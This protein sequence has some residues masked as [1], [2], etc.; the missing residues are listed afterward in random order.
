MAGVT[1][2][3]DK[4]QWMWIETLVL[5]FLA[6][7]ALAAQ[8]TSLTVVIH[9]IIG[10]ST[11]PTGLTLLTSGVNVWFGT[12]IAFAVLYWQF[13]RDGP[14]GR[15]AE[16]GRQADW[17]FPADTNPEA[18]KPG[19]Q[20]TFVDYLFLSFS[21]ATAFSTTDTVPLT[22]RAKLLMM[23][24]AAMSLATT[25]VVASRAINILGS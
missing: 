14:A 22:S 16:I 6:V 7:V 19:W 11:Q 4:R 21:T 10:G 3:D 20:P 17:L 24:E 23:L 8:V 15:M 5:R 1:W 18:V 12:V 25:L 13:D 2:A 9:Q